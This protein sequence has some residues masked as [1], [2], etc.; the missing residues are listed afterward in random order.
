[1]ASQHCFFQSDFAHRL[2]ETGLADSI[3][4]FCFGT[5]ASLPNENDLENAE[6]AHTC[7]QR[8]HSKDSSRR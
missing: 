5:V 2:S 1:M 7:W 6:A 3:C 4:L 8:T